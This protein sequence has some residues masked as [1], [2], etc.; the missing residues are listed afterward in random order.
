MLFSEPYTIVSTP[1]ISVFGHSALGEIKGA[2][3]QAGTRPDP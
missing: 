2:S 1:R 3:S